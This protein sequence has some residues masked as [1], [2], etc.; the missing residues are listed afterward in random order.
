VASLRRKPDVVAEAVLETP[1]MENAEPEVS[2]ATPTPELGSPQDDATLALQRQIDDLK[3][4]ETLQQQAQAMQAANERRQQWLAA[5]PGAMENRDA[6]GHIHRAA[7][8]TGL[9]DTSPQY[10]AFLESQLANLQQPAVAASRMGKEM[11]ERAAQSRTPEPPPRSSSGVYSAP[12]SRDIPDVTGSRQSNRRITL[13]PAE[14]E[15][16]RV[17]NV[18]VEEYARQKLKL[19]TMRETGQYSEDQRR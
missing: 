9:V 13:T 2:P 18:T 14:I 11:Q 4:S 1:T 12:V 17:S 16:A 3:K 6:L 10:F 7:L 8:D 19:R 5:T 15:M